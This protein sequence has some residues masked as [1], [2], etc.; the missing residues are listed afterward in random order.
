[1]PI[2]C[3]CGHADTPVGDAKYLSTLD[4]TKGYW[5]I[6]LNVEA[7]EKNAFATPLRLYHF[8]RMPFGLHRAATPFQ[9]LTDH[10]LKGLQGFAMAYIND[11]L[12]YTSTWEEHLSHLRQV[13]SVLK[14]ARLAVNRKKS[15]FGCT[16]LQYFCSN[17]GGGK[18]WAVQDKVEALDNSTPPHYALGT[19]KLSGFGQLLSPFCSPFCIHGRTL[20]RLAQDWGQSGQTPLPFP[21]SAP[22]LSGIKIAL[23]KQTVLHAPLS[24]QPFVFHTNAYSS[25]LGVVL[26]QPSPQGEQPIVYLR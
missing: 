21:R 16:V 12:V 2:P 4:L 9:R 15:F 22:S 24:N 1:M 23:C 3:P 14:H 5:Q 20:D 18:I 6:A 19:T 25:G 26:A 17:V 13:L 10:T 7:R 8:T 11:I